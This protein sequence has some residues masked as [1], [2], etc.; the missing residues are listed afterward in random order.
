MT[1]TENLIYAPEDLRRQFK[2]N[3]NHVPFTFKHR[4]AS[5]ELFQLPQL[6]DLIKRLDKFPGQVYYDLN[7]NSSVGR[8]WDQSGQYSA[9]PEQLIRS[10]EAVGAWMILK[11]TQTDPVYADFL[12]CCLGE[13]HEIS[14][15]DMRRDTQNHIMSVI[16]T[17]P[18]RVTPYHI[19][20]ECNYLFQIRGSKHVYVFDGSDRSV[21]S[22]AE[23][24][25]FWVGDLN[26]AK[27]RESLQPKA[28]AFE[29]HP[30]DAVHVPVNYPHWVKNGPDVSISVSMNFSFK[31]TSVADLYRANRQLRRLG[32]HASPPG[33]S[34]LADAAK[35]M[36]YRLQSV[37]RKRLGK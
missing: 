9:D 31:D 19:D 17:S 11:S 12:E 33:Q 23:L 27:Y 4:I 15:R 37:L 6:T 26:A 25:E 7:S 32:V 34:K 21:L 13:L 2:E 29:L 1:V 3:Y 24:E 8:G 10:M 30:G 16:V 36:S 20:G 14:G 18:G 35:L 5:H 28:S 22:H